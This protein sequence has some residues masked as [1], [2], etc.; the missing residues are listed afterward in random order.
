MML[1]AL[2]SVRLFD[3]KA[4][5]DLHIWAI[6]FDAH[7][8]PRG[9]GVY[10]FYRQSDLVAIYVGS[11]ASLRS[12][13]GSYRK[14]KIKPA[15]MIRRRKLRVRVW[16]TNTHSDALK[17][18]ADAIITYLPELNQQYTGRPRRREEVPAQPERLARCIFCKSSNHDSQ[19]CPDEAVLNEFHIKLAKA[20]PDPDAVNAVMAKYEPRILE[21][22]GSRTRRR[23]RTK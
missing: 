21:I 14:C 13:I 3:H 15:S 4:D 17:Y 12:R 10:C 20:H 19:S 1:P 23:V 18:E 16:R 6:D 22:L 2:P 11:S 8:I 9:A 7:R 5:A